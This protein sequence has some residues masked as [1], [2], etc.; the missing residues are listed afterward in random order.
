MALRIKAYKEDKEAYKQERAAL[1]QQEELIAK[2]NLTWRSLVNRA[3]LLASQ[4][5]PEI[6]EKIKSIPTASYSGGAS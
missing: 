3:V 4:L 1:R 6:I 5:T 2:A